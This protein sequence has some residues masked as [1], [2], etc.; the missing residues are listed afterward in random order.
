MEQASQGSRHCPTLPELEERW[1]SALRHRFG[2]WV[3]LCGAGGWTQRSL[4]VPPNLGSSVA[5]GRAALGHHF[6]F[7]HALPLGWVMPRDP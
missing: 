5:D 3:F 7:L 4:W 2:F 1:G 6:L